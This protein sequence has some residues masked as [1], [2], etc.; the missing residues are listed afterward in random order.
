MPDENKNDVQDALSGLRTALEGDDT[1][2]IRDA[3]EKLAV[4]SQAM[5]TAI[6][7]NAS[8]DAA[9]QAAGGDAD[10]GADPG[11]AQADEGVVEAEV[12]DEDRQG[13]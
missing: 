3:Q 9:A 6:Y 8:A 2:A 13:S 1:G 12:V 10:G 7:A 11:A 5:G 4:A